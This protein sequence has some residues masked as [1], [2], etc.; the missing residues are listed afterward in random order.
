MANRWHKVVVNGIARYR[1]SAS[2]SYVSYSVE[3]DSWSSKM[4]PG[5]LPVEQLAKAPKVIKVKGSA[6]GVEVVRSYMEG[7]L[8][9]THLLAFRGRGARTT[10]IDGKNV[11]TTPADPTHVSFSST[12]AIESRRS[13]S[14]EQLARFKKRIAEK[15]AGTAGEFGWGTE[16]N[17]VIIVELS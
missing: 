10:W 1:S 16:Y 12:S 9:V 17:D 14:V 8:P 2:K 13:D 3:K 15:A 6:W 7:E 5:N 11:E 4:L